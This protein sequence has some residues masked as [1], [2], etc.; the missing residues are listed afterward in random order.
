MWSVY[1][2]F[3][4]V[5]PAEPPLDW[6]SRGGGTGSEEACSGQE[7][8]GVLSLSRIAMPR[9]PLPP[10]YRSL[11]RTLVRSGQSRRRW[12]FVCRGVRMA[13]W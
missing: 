7:I 2:R 8:G 11:F 10:C 4:S 6:L 5:E 9:G 13:P 1:M 3:F 12:F